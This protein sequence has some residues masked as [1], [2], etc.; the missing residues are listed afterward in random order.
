VTPNLSVSQDKSLADLAVNLPTSP[1]L[2]DFAANVVGYGLAANKLTSLPEY[3]NFSKDQTRQAWQKLEEQYPYPKGLGQKLSFDPTNPQ[4]H[5]QPNGGRERITPREKA[6]QNTIYVEGVR[7]PRFAPPEAFRARHSKEE[8]QTAGV[9]GK[10]TRMYAVD[11]Y[12][13]EPVVVGH[14]TT[15]HGK[16]SAGILRAATHGQ[17]EVI[18]IDYA[19]PVPGASH[20]NPY[21]R[22]ILSVIDIEAKRQGKTRETVDLTGVTISLSQSQKADNLFNTSGYTPI[23]AMVTAR[24]GSV[25]LSA[26]NNEFNLIAQSAREVN[27][28]DGSSEKIGTPINATQTPS[29]LYNNGGTFLGVPVTREGQIDPSSQALTMPSILQVR[30]AANGSLEFKDD[31]SPTGW[32]LLVDRQDVRVTPLAKA[33]LAGAQ[34]GKNLKLTDIAD[35]VQ[36]HATTANLPEYRDAQNEQALKQAIQAESNRRF[37]TNAMISV[38]ELTPFSTR[39]DEGFRLLLNGMVPAGRQAKDIFISTDQL[40][41]SNLNTMQAYEIDASNKLVP[42]QSE[43]VYV[44]GTSWATPYAAASGAIYRRMQ[45]NKAKGQ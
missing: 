40:F 13:G 24:G 43:S 34:A 7:I 20:E 29:R 41:T 38:E 42:V 39:T 18:E 27:V 11:T 19:K 9:T 30:T 32:S 2:Q 45:I 23:L 36:W 10:N 4:L 25:Y 31:A 14:A 8:I 37:G 26:G 16:I 3:N 12:S 17:A 21:A 33:E 1:G 5:T 28:V 44:T 22:A 35:F 15:Y 6:E